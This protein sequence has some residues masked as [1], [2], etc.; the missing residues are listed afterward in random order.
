M[1]EM[2]DSGIEWIGKIPETWLI[3]QLK[4]NCK[5]I[6]GNTPNTKISIWFDGDIN[7]FTP[8]DFTDSYLLIESKRKLSQKAVDHGV[9]TLFPA[10]INLLVGIGATAGKVGYCTKRAYGNQQVTAICNNCNLL[11]KY[12]TYY[13]VI[14]GHVMFETSMFTT[15]P[16]L[17]N[18][19]IGKFPLLMPP[20]AEQQAIADFLDA[21]CADIDSLTADIQKQINILK[22]Y[23][24]S[25]ITQAVTKGLDPNV[26]MKD[27]GIAWI[28]KIPRHWAL[29]R[30][31][32]TANLNGR[33]G[34]QG[35]TSKEYQYEGAILVTGVNFSLGRINWES[36]YR[37]SFE[38]WKQAP[39]IQLKNG[40]LLITKDGTVGKVAIVKDLPQKATLN[41]GVLKI[42][43]ETRINTKFMYWVLLSEEF[44]RWFTYKNAGSSTILHLYQNDFT[45]F[46]YAVPPLKEQ[47]AIADFLDAKCADIDAAIAGKQKQLDVLKEYKKSLIYEYVTGKKEVPCHE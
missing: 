34:W 10:D 31:K 36:C 30:I 7:W 19:T 39:E 40:D 42:T 35:L 5:L 8:S 46:K 28:G 32:H 6:T 2:K 47:K 45:E 9:I 4:R 24:K 15:L 22:E 26:E 37:V 13:L 17:N 11:A 41:S 1:R 23:K 33:I 3:S 12:I 21:K 27:S 44:W 25:V 43:L 38:R 29:K 20:L 18:S 14:A 16:I